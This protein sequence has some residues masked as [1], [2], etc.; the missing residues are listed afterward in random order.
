[1]TE[2]DFMSR[3]R[4][5]SPPENIDDSTVTLSTDET[6]HLTHVL[7]LTP[8]SPAFAFDGCGHE[9]KCT[10][11]GITD[12]RARLE[13]NE[14]LSHVVES[15]LQLTLAQALAKGEKFDL[16][17]QKATELGVSRIVPLMTRYA[18]VKLDD[19]MITRRLDRWRRISLEA[20]KQCGRRRLVEITT[21]RTLP[22]LF[23]GVAAPD[24]ANDAG[25]NVAQA[26]S[27]Q[28]ESSETPART[29]AACATF[30]LFSE[31]GGVAITEAL[32]GIPKPASI[33][34]LVG[35]EGGWSD[36]ELNLLEHHGAKPVS[37]GPR[38]LRTETAAVV[39]ITLIQHLTGD[40][41]VRGN[42]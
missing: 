2:G 23:D 36:D 41:S 17:I 18:D 30:L 28:T 37:L 40:L 6:H 8:G 20:L 39:A 33:V 35:P 11:R 38:V 9:Y 1:M 12:N 7:R 27:L 42:E 21:P 26:A 16:I 14:S 24:L 5:Y 32:E 10:F 22:Q 29:P 4:F 15:S 31:R 3:R 25:D 34:A 13:I 19:Q